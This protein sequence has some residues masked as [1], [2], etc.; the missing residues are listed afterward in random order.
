MIIVFPFFQDNYNRMLQEQ[1]PKKTVRKKPKASAMTRP[2]KRN[3]KKKKSAPSPQ[4]AP[5]LQPANPLPPLVPPKQSIQQPQIQQVSPSMD[6]YNHDAVMHDETVE[7]MSKIP[8]SIMA[9]QYLSDNAAIYQF[10]QTGLPNMAQQELF[11]V[12]E[13]SSAYESSEDTGV[14][15]LSESELMGASDG[16]GYFE[17]Y[18]YIYIIK[19]MNRKWKILIELFIF[20]FPF[21][22]IPLSDARL[23]EEHD[24]TNVFNQLPEDAFNELFEGNYS[25]TINHQSLSKKSVFDFSSTE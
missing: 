16:I 1:K 12:C 8:I 21:L 5:N 24:L 23:L 18:L 19:N 15:G 20:H 22:E 7:M 17:F 11:T 2:P 10:A 6:L 14:G 3:K 4:P 13:N 9:N 25:Q